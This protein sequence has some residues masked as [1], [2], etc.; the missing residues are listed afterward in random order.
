[1]I[2]FL[3]IKAEMG[4]RGRPQTGTN[5][6]KWSKWPKMEFSGKLW[7]NGVVIAWSSFLFTDIIATAPSDNIFVNKGGG[8]V[9]RLLISRHR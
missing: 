6:E 4:S 7:E 8:R 3:S 1:M 5:G 2:T 9:K